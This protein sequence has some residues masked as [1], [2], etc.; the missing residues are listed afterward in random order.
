MIPA[1]VEESIAVASDALY[2]A[3]CRTASTASASAT[4][5]WITGIRDLRLLSPRTVL[6]RPSRSG[7]SAIRRRRP[8]AWS[9]RAPCRFRTWWSP[10]RRQRPVTGSGT[11]GPGLAAS[12]NWL[13]SCGKVPRTCTADAPAVP[14]VRNTSASSISVSPET[15]QCRLSRVRPPRRIPQVNV[16]SPDPVLPS[17]DRR[18][19]F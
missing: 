13:G 8:A 18:R 19:R 17:A 4:A 14:P 16:Q 10:G 11:S 6:A 5:G 3:A 15:S 9:C 7:T 1:M 12:T 2:G